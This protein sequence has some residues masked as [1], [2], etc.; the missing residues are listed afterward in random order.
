M[1]YGLNDEIETVNGYNRLN[2]N[3][4]PNSSIIFEP[5][6]MI[7]MD[8]RLILEPT[9]F[10][11]G[12]IFSAFKRSIAGQSFIDSQ[13]TNKTS[14]K[15]KLS[16]C[17]TL[18]GTINKIEILPNQV[19]RFT[20]SSFIACTNNIIVSGNLNIFSNF[21]AFMGG[22]NILYT[23]VRTH[24]NNPGIIWISSHGGIEK[25]EIRMGSEKI[26]INDGVFLGMLAEDK[27]KK[28]NYWNSFV[29][30]GSANGFFKGLL[31]NSALL[32]NIHDQYN[33][34]PLNTTCIVYTQ[35]LNIR[36]LH[37][38]I[39]LIAQNSLQNYTSDVPNMGLSLLTGGNNYNKLHKYHNKLN[40][41]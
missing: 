14:D 9:I 37:N 12:G 31:T 29:H 21:K 27:N 7:H 41:I 25:Q 15:L 32:L 8:G 6:T 10:S 2:F 40:I 28:I 4:E 3:L 16:L 22:Q 13:I 24:D 39:Q 11:K 18:L 20:P 34:A 1:N 30:I 19:W 5:S 26:V 38:F 33:N 36:N 17:P 35:S 23:E